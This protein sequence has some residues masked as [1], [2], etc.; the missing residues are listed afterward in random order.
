MIVFLGSEHCKLNTAHEYF[1][2]LFP[3]H[4]IFELW[5]KVRANNN[6]PF[7]STS[8]RARWVPNLCGLS[9]LTFEVASLGV[10]TQSIER[11]IKDLLARFQ[12]AG[13]QLVVVSRRRDC[14][15]RRKR[16]AATMRHMRGQ[17]AHRG[18]IFSDAACVRGADAAEHASGQIW[19]SP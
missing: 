7:V 1:G 14:S 18:V 11:T 8:W 12:G 17:G 9:G 10:D 19:Q 6:F 4:A 13:G 5:M 3:A 16:V 2:W 15:P